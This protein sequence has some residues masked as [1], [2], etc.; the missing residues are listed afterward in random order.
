MT[1]VAEDVRD[2]VHDELM[3]VAAPVKRPDSEA[4]SKNAPDPVTLTLIVT[5]VLIP[6]LTGLTSGILTHLATRKGSGVTESRVADLEAQLR[7]LAHRDEPEDGAVVDA[8]VH[9]IS[10]LPFDRTQLV[11]A[12]AEPA[13]A[14]NVAAELRRFHL[15]DATSTRLAPLIIKRAL[16]ALS[17]AAPSQK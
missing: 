3:G 10:T 15:S 8:I 16:A 7:A 12:A 14:M 6:I 9:T 17:A 11:A 13:V 1:S 4:S 2:A 5:Q